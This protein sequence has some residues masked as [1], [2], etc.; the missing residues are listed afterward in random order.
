MPALTVPPRASCSPSGGGGSAVGVWP[1]G[2]HAGAY[3]RRVSAGLAPRR[4][5]SARPRPVRTATPDAHSGGGGGRGGGGGGGK[6]RDKPCHGT[7]VAI[8]AAHG[9]IVRCPAPNPSYRNR[10]RNM[11]PCILKFP[12]LTTQ[13][14]PPQI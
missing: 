14:H 5:G 9:T 6:S 8:K 3:E 2:M 4:G 7:S 11:E 1:R 13:A 12:S 10:V